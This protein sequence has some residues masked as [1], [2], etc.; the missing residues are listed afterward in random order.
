MKALI[1]AARM[2]A[3]FASMAALPAH[4]STLEVATV[5]SAVLGLVGLGAWFAADRWAARAIGRT[6]TA[7]REAARAAG[8]DVAA[9]D[10]V[11]AWRTARL[12]LDRVATEMRERNRSESERLGVLRERLEENEW[13]YRLAVEDANDGMWEWDLKADRVWFSPRWKSMLG[14][15]DR[16]VSGTLD[17]WRSRIHPDDVDAVT[18]AVR[19]HLEEGTPRIEI[20]YRIRH[21]DGSYRCVLTRAKAVR[22]ANGAPYRLIG[23]NIDVTARWQ[24][25]LIL[26]QAADELSGLNGVDCYRTLIA[27][28]AGAVGMGEVFLCECCDQPP[29][30]VRMLAHWREGSFVENKEFDLAGTPCQD[31]IEGGRVVYAPRELGERWPREGKGASQAYLGV[32]CF[33]SRGSV[34]GHI[35]AKNVQAM[36][37]DLP[38]GAVM[39]LFALRAALEMERR[40]MA[41]PPP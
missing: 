9:D 2:A 27:R 19:V 20:E 23:L 37:P 13:R 35:A 40:K 25:G 3:A 11:D 1:P 7:A 26:G 31:V 15:A 24:I 10:P 41:S 18:D 30:R 38:H 6:G 5:A 32:P 14:Y 17:E 33:D 12:A 8:V 4:A 16:E 39:R 28:F 36:G 34:I 22:H 21:R 29:T